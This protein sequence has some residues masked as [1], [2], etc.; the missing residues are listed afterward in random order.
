MGGRA[1][2]AEWHADFQRRFHETLHVASLVPQ[3]LTM[4]A[5][6]RAEFED[7]DPE[8]YKKVERQAKMLKARVR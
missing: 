3:W 5:A 8:M 1:R 4:S 2:A 6:E 7:A